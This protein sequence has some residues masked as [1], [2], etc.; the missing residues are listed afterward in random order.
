MPEDSLQPQSHELTEI[1]FECKMCGVCCSQP[2]LIIT[3][4]GHDVVRIARGLGL[5]G[6]EVL[7]ALDFY[8]LEDVEFIPRGLRD[9]PAF[10]SEHGLAYMALRK[11]DGVSCVFL[12]NNLCMIHPIRPGACMSFPFT[13]RVESGTLFWGL[14]AKQDICPGLGNGETISKDHLY[15]LGRP[16]LEEI[17]IYREFVNEWN[18]LNIDHTAAKFVEAILANS[19]FV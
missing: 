10:K 5:S 4:T 12:H 19:V 9:I 8:L 11:L 14:S 7:R 16:I 3:V 17:N 18:K 13:F 6:A 1:Q 15:N 2:D